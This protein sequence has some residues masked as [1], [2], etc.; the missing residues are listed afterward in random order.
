MAYISQVTKTS[1]IN[2]TLTSTIKRT[3]TSTSTVTT[4]TS[5]PGPVI[6]LIAYSDRLCGV[7]P[8][9]SNGNSPNFQSIRLTYD[10]TAGRSNCARVDQNSGSFSWNIISFAA[11]PDNCSIFFYSSDSCVP[12]RS[13]STQLSLTNGQGGCH[14]RR[15]SHVR[16]VRMSCGGA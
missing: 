2:Q 13:G 16:S 1:T 4:T 15:L 10:T 7:D 6:D 11:V 3:V 9:S 12:D 14:S 8:V 5:T